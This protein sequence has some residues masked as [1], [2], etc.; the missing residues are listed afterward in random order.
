[1]VDGGKATDTPAAVVRYASR[2]NQ[3]VVT[4]TVTDIAQRVKE[5]G[6]TSP[7]LIVIG[8]VA[9]KHATLSFKA[10]CRQISELAQLQLDLA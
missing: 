9:Q 3:Q 4:G 8:G 7:A 6:I 5:E 2:D 1:L 10:T